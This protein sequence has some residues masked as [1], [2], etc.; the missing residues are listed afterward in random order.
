MVP[1]RFP[2]LKGKMDRAEARRTREVECYAQDHKL[3]TTTI[4]DDDI[5]SYFK[6]AAM[7]LTWKQAL[8][9]VGLE[10]GLVEC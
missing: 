5:I 4:T 10:N 6:E 1:T 2:R 9:A 7:E 3:H 8:L